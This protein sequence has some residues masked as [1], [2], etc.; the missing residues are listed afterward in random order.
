MNFL[1]HLWLAERSGTSLA[2]SILGDVVRGAELSAYPDDMVLGIRLHRRVDALTDRHPA[3]HAARAA[4]GDG[5]RRYAGI[6]LDLVGDHVLSADWPRYSDDTLDAF[7][8]R[9]GAAI[10]AAAPWF[11][12]AGGRSSSAA[13]FAELLRS[14][15]TVAGLDRAI[16]R[17]AQRLRDPAPLLAAGE[18]WQ[19]HVPAMQLALPALLDDLLRVM[20]DGA[21]AAP[22]SARTMR[23]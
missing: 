1:A 5:A 2:G 9:A 20:R 15:G 7:R 18:N 14:Y 3:L 16:A 12:L 8:T 10:E 21:S 13:G 19:R 17:T 23:G 4:F 6:V 22:S 11:V